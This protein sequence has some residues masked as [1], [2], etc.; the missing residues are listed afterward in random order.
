MESIDVYL[1][2]VSIL[3]ITLKVFKPAH[4]VKLSKKLILRIM[5]V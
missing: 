5:L 1:N 4:F 2:Q 3:I